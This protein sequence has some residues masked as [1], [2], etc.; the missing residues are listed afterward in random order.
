MAKV[1]DFNSNDYF[2]KSYH[3]FYFQTKRLDLILLHLIYVPS[4]MFQFCSMGAYMFSNILCS[5]NI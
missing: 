1:Q 5:S 3:F 4:L 2:Y